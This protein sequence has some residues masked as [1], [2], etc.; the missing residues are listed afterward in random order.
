[1]IHLLHGSTNP[2]TA[3]TKPI[4][5]LPIITIFFTNGTKTIKKL[6]S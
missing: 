5:P 1:M 3:V 2:F 6:T 4:V